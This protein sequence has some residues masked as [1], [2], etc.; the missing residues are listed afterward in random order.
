MSVPGSAVIFQRTGCWRQ[1]SF[2]ADAPRLLTHATC[3]LLPTPPPR[4]RHLYRRAPHYL[5]AV[6]AEESCQRL[7][8]PG[9]ELDAMGLV[10]RE[11]DSFRACVYDDFEREGGA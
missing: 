6:L 1:V 7:G 11:E 3:P 4:T 10:G 8:G 9:G 5:D 2:K